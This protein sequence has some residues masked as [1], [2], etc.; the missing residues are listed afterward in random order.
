M[1]G[2]DI[3]PYVAYLAGGMGFVMTIPQLRRIRRSAPAEIQGVAFS[4]WAY[5]AAC[6]IAY[7]FYGLDV[8]HAMLVPNIVNTAAAIFMCWQLHQRRG[9][10]LAKWWV[11]WIG[12]AL[13]SS[14]SPTAAVGWLGTFYALLQRH[15]QI[16]A[17]LRIA[18]ARA[19]ATVLPISSGV[20]VLAWWLSLTCTALW[21]LFGVLL[22]DFN[23]IVCNVALMAQSATILTIEIREN[24]RAGI[25]PA[26]VGAVQEA[27]AAPAA[28]AVAE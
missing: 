12:T 23:L 14:V 28:A 18:R 9:D 19:A 2:E 17:S 27:A 6:C 1:S 16:V 3:A 8:S 25:H 20:S 26:A 5:I 13:I 22:T 4:T 21:V 24:R 7:F 10:A 11:L 15:P